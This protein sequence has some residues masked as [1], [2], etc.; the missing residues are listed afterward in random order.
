ML[1][2]THSITLPPSPP[3]LALRPCSDHVTWTRQTGDSEGNVIQKGISQDIQKGISSSHCTC[4]LAGGGDCG[5][6]TAAG[7]PDESVAC[8]TVCAD[9]CVYVCMCVC[10]YTST[11]V[12]AGDIHTTRRAG[13]PA[14]PRLA[15]PHR[16]STQ[17]LE[18]RL[19]AR[20][21]V[22]GNHAWTLVHHAGACDRCY[23]CARVHQVNKHGEREQGAGWWRPPD[24]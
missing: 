8:T 6:L 15:S 7:V 11:G 18:A 1:P 10:M 9:T 12:F 4:D 16:V 22:A 23:P 14:D 20:A 3:S 5:D 13:G 17:G 24:L 21:R 19:R 2:L